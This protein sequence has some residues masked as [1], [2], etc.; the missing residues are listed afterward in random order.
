MSSARA[1]LSRSS[2]LVAC[3]ALLLGGAASGRAQGKGE[4][5]E[6]LAL[7]PK[8]VETVPGHIASLS[9]RVTSKS[10]RQELLREQVLVPEGWQV[11]VPPTALPLEP[12]ATQVRI[13][14]LK[15]P[16]G[17]PAGQYEVRYEVQGEVNR[18]IRDSDSVFIAVAAV[19]RLDLVVERQPSTV[20]AGDAYEAA[21]RVVNRGNS[22]VTVALTAVSD[23]KFPAELEPNTVELPAD[24]NQPVTLRVH[25]D[26]RET[27]SRS[28]HVTVTADPEADGEP[29]SVSISVDLVPRQAPK[30]DLYRRLPMEASVRVAGDEAG[31]V[32]QGELSGAGPL[33]AEETRHV[34]FLFRGP[35]SWPESVLGMR[36]EYRLTYSQR[37]L[38]VRLGDQPYRLSRL[39]HDYGLER[40][41]EIACDVTPQWGI[42]AFYSYNRWSEGL[43]DRWQT[44]FSVERRLRGGQAARLNYLHKQRDVW[45][46]ARGLQADVV[47]LQ[48]DLEPADHH[49][50][51]V[52]LGFSE[53]EDGASG[54]G[55]LLE[56]D[57]PAAHGYYALSYVRAGPDFA[58]YYRDASYLNVSVSHPVTPDLSAHLAYSRWD[59]NLEADPNRGPGSRE[60][61]LQFGVGYQISPSWYANLDW[62]HMT[63]RAAVEPLQYRD[64]EMLERIGISYTRPRYSVRLQTDLSQR[65]NL[66]TGGRENQVYFDAYATYR[67]GEDLALTG[68]GSFGQSSQAFS[69]LRGGTGNAGLGVHWTPN[70]RFLVDLHYNRYGLN[71]Q[72]HQLD[73]L[74][75]RA[76]YTLP[77]DYRLALELRR[78]APFVGHWEG[79]RRT[80][81]LL[82]LTVPLDVRLGRRT[83][84]GVLRGR[85][86]DATQ[87]GRPGLRNV[88]VVSGEGGGS[89]ATNANGEFAFPALPPGQYTIDVTRV[90]IGLDR[91]AETELPAAFEVRPGQTTEVEI[92][93]VPAAKVTGS[94]TVYPSRANGNGNGNGAIKGPT[95]R[96]TPQGDIVVEGDPYVSRPQ[97]AITQPTTNGGNGGNGPPTAN[98]GSAANGPPD[99]SNHVSSDAPLTNVYVEL[100]NG[101]SILRTVTD[102]RGAFVF[103]SLRPGRY[104]LK[105]DRNAVPQFHFMENPEQDIDLQAGQDLS[106]KVR[107]LPTA[108]KVRIIDEGAV[109][110]V[111]GTGNTNAPGAQ[112]PQR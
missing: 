6:V 35:D 109:P 111:Q 78:N 89:V 87:E 100:S 82:S 37:A 76:E 46:D 64:R 98:I 58:G 20:L 44:G 110:S 9:F 84:V 43:D 95:S 63:R 94:V 106:V 24:G 61:L 51:S 30:V 12:G 107:V 38:Q 83:D 57:G 52:E 4:G 36:D 97:G 102:S 7:S 70:P 31:A 104:H 10:P 108:R 1:I 28:H 75:G 86:Y 42:R 68:Y 81:Y 19:S 47:S 72:G 11:V 73:Q 53:R 55:C 85:V 49:N 40:G 56:A 39:T 77:N 34:D 50:L 32:V 62:Q 23:Y 41:G 33:D 90:S 79:D 48:A 88:V 91:V 26:L 2:S 13:M 112:T 21:L 25:T 80:E 71:S 22:P 96:M 3:A 59:Q 18:A 67:P 65:E 8:G 16:R 66:L 74:Y 99:G 92:S 15:V 69:Y 45:S 27:I 29:V 5:V 14:A 101:D 105:V 93:V 54:L 17:T 60:Q 103:D